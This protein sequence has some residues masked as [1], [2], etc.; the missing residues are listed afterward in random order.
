MQA[1]TITANAN[2]TA[3]KRLK[4]FS[5]RNTVA[6]GS[7]NLR[8]SAVG[9]QILVVLEMPI[10][11]SQTVIFDELLTANGDGIYVQVVSGTVAGVLYS[12]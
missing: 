10:A 11:S 2:H 6:A 7:I 9:G 3:A 1:V 12:A 4:G 8:D 5:I